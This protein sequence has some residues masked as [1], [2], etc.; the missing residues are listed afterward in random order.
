MTFT[1][2][3]GTRDLYRNPR[4]D[5][6]SPANDNFHGIGRLVTSDELL[7]CPPEDAAAVLALLAALTPEYRLDQLREAEEQKEQEERRRAAVRAGF[8]RAR[9]VAASTDGDRD[10]DNSAGNN[11]DNVASLPSNRSSNQGRRTAEPPEAA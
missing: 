11:S 4:F 2:S 8:R 10:G 9:G 1:P 7:P 5:N 6:E 3:F